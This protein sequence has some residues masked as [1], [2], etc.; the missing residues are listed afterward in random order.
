MRERTAITRDPSTDDLDDAGIVCPW[1]GC[2]VPRRV[3]LDR[4]LLGQRLFARRERLRGCETAR[5]GPRVVVPP[6]S[7]HQHLNIVMAQ[8]AL[9]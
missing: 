5:L 3:T 9:S 6:P 4:K 8:L 7:T 2:F 1:I